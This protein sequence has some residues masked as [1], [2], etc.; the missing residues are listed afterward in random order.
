METK[1]VGQC[2]RG[3]A[4]DLNVGCLSAKEKGED[5]PTHDSES[6]SPWPALVTEKRLNKRR[7][8][9]HQGPAHNE[10]VANPDIGR[11]LCMICAFP[12]VAHCAPCLAAGRI[13]PYCRRACQTYH[14]RHAGHKH[15]CVASKPT[16]SAS[17]T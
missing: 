14:W 9:G 17:G 12:S 10:V 4:G 15:A 1:I 7:E 11:D 13:F 2:G 6:A 16:G 3:L 8:M 5:S